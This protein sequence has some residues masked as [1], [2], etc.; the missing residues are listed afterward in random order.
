MRAFLL[1]ALLSISFLSFAQK[2]IQGFWHDSPHVGSG[3]GEY[4]AFYDNMNFT[5]STNSM[6]CDQRLQSFSGVYS[7]EGDSVFLYI[8]EINIIIG[9]TIKEDVTSCYNGFYIEGGEYLKIETRKDYVRKYII[10]FSTY[11]E[12]DL[13]YTTICING[14]TYYRLGTDPSVYINE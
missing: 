14:K 4:Y 7:V 3:Y 5:Y 9:G 11:F 12:E 13:E 2:D 10:S 6:D 8:R 1:F